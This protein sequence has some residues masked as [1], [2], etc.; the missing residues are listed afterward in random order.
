MNYRPTKSSVERFFVA[1][2]VSLYAYYLGNGHSQSIHKHHHALNLVHALEHTRV[3]H[4][5]AAAFTAVR[6]EVCHR[7]HRRIERGE[8]LLLVVQLRALLLA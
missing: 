8:I 3:R 7:D 1:V 4:I 2:S 6:N 5:R